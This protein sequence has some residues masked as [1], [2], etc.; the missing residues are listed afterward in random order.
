MSGSSGMKFHSVGKS[1]SQGTGGVASNKNIMSR[2]TI[3]LAT[4]A[5][6]A[7]ATAAWA[8]TIVLKNRSTFN[9]RIVKQDL[10]Q[11]TIRTEFGTITFNRRVIQKVSKN[12]LVPTRRVR[13]STRGSKSAT[14]K[15]NSRRAA[16]AK[17]ARKAR[18]W[19]RGKA[20][21]KRKARKKPG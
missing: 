19:K 14:A 10:K 6:G 20:S 18:S 12:D 15:R 2:L 3:I 8:D 1:C 16:T 9:G 17:K 13:K 7:F 4:L 5:L 11:V 21:S